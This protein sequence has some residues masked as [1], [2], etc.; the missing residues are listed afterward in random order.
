[1]LAA[2][3]DFTHRRAGGDDHQ[4]GRVQA[5]DL[6]VQ[7]D[8]AGGEAGQAAV[9]AVGLGG[10]G[11]RALQGGGEADEAGRDAAGLGEFEQLLFGLLDLVAGV[12]LG[13][14]LL[15][16]GGDVP[17][18]ADQVA[19]QRQVVDRAGVVRGVG[20][21]RGAVDEVGEIAHAA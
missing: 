1:M 8:Q 6:L 18:D 3:E 2:S 11:D 10:H 20:G 15:G 21:R 14:A 12:E 13:V 5:A 9:A 4:V 17:A 16:E 19:P 7:V